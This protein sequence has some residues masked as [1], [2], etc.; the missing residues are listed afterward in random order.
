MVEIAVIV[1]ST[2]LKQVMLNMGVML[3]EVVHP[4]VLA[5]MELWLTQQMVVQIG[6][7]KLIL[8]QKYR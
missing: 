4:E 5:I 6:L 7:L 1:L 3:V 2:L 8:A